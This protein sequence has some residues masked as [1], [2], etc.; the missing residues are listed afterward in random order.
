MHEIA[1]GFL[2]LFF[3]EIFPALDVIIFS[4]TGI[5]TKEYTKE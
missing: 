5:L 2:I 3:F 4:F 1:I